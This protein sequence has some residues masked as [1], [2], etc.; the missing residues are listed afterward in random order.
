MSP[1]SIVGMK[2]SNRCRSDPQIAVRVILITASCGLMIP[3]SG[4]CSVSNLFF[5]IQQTAFICCTPYLIVSTVDSCEELA[6]AYPALRNL[7]G[8]V[9]ISSPYSDPFSLPLTPRGPCGC[10]LVV[11]ISPVSI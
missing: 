1:D 6:L 2:P 7:P 8:G 4:T 11:G 9:S 5:P 3:G 10:P